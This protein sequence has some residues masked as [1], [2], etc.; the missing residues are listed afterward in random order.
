MFSRARVSSVGF[1][2]ASFKTFT[3][4]A[5]QAACVADAS[6]RLSESSLKKGL[7]LNIR[8]EVFIRSSVYQMRL[9]RKQASFDGEK[10]FIHEATRSHTKQHEQECADWLSLRVIPVHVVSCDF[11]D[12]IFPPHT[13]NS[14]SFAYAVAADTGDA[15]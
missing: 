13:S 12:K 7:G 1:D 15:G 2:T 14:R 5:A 11:V 10:D 6:S 9:P 4:G 8:V 3:R